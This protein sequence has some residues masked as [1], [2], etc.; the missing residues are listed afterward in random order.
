LPR[1]RFNIED[2]SFVYLFVEEAGGEARRM[3][4]IAWRNALDRDAKGFRTGTVG[5][6]V[7][8]NDWLRLAGD[9]EVKGKVLAGKKNRERFF[10]VGRE[11]EGT[12]VIALLNFPRDQKLAPA[13][14]RHAAFG[15]LP[16][17][18]AHHF[19]LS[20]EELERKVGLSI[21]AGEPAEV[22]G[23]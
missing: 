7:T 2:I 9:I 20:L 12:N 21:L 14:P 13:V 3:L 22:R 19:Q 18:I 15:F 4:L 23:R 17:Q 6:T 16:A 11:V 8:T 1:R 5:K 10:V